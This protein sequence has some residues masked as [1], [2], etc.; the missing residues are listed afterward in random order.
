M[1]PHDVQKNAAISIAVIFLI[2]I[3]PDLMAEAG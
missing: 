1:T 2:M 3:I